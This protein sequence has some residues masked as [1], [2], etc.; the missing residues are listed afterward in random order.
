MADMNINSANVEGGAA[1]IASA[2]NC[3]EKRTL[4][5][6][7]TRSTISANQ[8]SKSAFQEA[9]SNM[10]SF[11]AALDQDA[12]NIRSMNVAFQ[13]YDAMISDMLRNG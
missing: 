5:S 2:A 9:Q 1:R 13:Q 10:E 7:D 3:F 11:A 4:P 12:A 6:K 8:K